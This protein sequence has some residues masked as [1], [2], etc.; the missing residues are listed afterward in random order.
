MAFGRLWWTGS[1]LEFLPFGAFGINVSRSSFGNRDHANLAQAQIDRGLPGAVVESAVVMA[2]KPELKRIG[3]GPARP[4]FFCFFFPGANKLDFFK[5]FQ[6]FQPGIRC[7]CPPP[8]RSTPSPPVR[9]PFLRTLP[10]LASGYVLSVSTLT[11]LEPR[12]K[13]SKGALRSQ[14]A[15]PSGPPSQFVGGYGRGLVKGLCRIWNCRRRRIPSG[16]VSFPDCRVPALINRSGVNGLSR[17]AC[18]GAP[19]KRVKAYDF[20]GLIEKTFPSRDE[21]KDPIPLPRL[22]RCEKM[23]GQAAPSAEQDA[24]P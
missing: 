14:L 23:A 2:S 9:G 19:L 15:L 24:R 3:V 20:L 17:A 11:A 1:R 16:L 13:T 7:R 21:V 5:L 4:A 8:V 12:A 18:G 22:T 10:S 6:P